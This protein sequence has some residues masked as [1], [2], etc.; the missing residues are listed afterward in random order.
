MTGSY[1][2][3]RLPSMSAEHIGFRCAARPALPNTTPDA[4]PDAG[5]DDQ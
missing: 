1:R 4:T 3:G 2:R 5:T